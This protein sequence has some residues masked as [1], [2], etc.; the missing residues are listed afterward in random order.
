MTYLTQFFLPFDAIFPKKSGHTGRR[1]AARQ[2][3]T[4]DARQKRPRTDPEGRPAARITTA[5][6][7]RESGELDKGRGVIK[8]SIL[9]VQ[10]PRFVSP[11]PVNFSGGGILAAVSVVGAA[12]PAH[13]RKAREE[14]REFW[15]TGPGS[16][17]RPRTGPGRAT[18]TDLI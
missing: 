6:E 2:N 17:R 3:R 15:K 4:T 7:P 16:T 1:G 13:G 10:K 8:Q 18:R 11:G 12:L 9:I 5:K 14:E